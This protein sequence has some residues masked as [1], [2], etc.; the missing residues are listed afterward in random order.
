MFM[1]IR[2]LA[3]ASIALL[4][5]PFFADLPAVASA[6]AGAATCPNLYRNLSFG[7][8]GIDVV[9]LQ[10]FLITQGDLAAGNNTGYFGRLTEAAV[11]SWQ[12]R[13]GIVSSGTATTTG[14][15]AVGPRTR[16]NMTSV[17]GGGGTV[18]ANFSASPISGAAPLTVSFNYPG[19]T[20]G[21][22]S[23]DYGDGNSQAMKF[24]YP[25][26]TQIP[27]G[28]KDC[29]YYES[30][31]AYT[32]A[33][34]YTAKLMRD[35]TDCGVTKSIPGQM[36]CGPATV[37]GTV[38]IT[39]GGSANANVYLTRTPSPLS[40][41]RYAAFESP[42]PLSENVSAYSIDFGDGTTQKMG[43][44]MACA[45]AGGCTRFE[46]MHADHLY[47]AA[48]TYIVKLLRSAFA[49]PENGSCPPP[50]PV[51]IEPHIVNTITVTIP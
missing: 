6:Q 24:V 50:P 23:V 48:G 29:S 27:A 20:S 18:S 21:T 10:N 13:N 2:L 1:T 47:T 44:R 17:C 49:C 4:L 45:D 51:W 3:A 7:S 34:T 32:N 30:S 33:G 8:R 11:K 9:Q 46:G 39:V 41:P 36:Y 19:V 31:H 16:A 12:S 40:D 38:T 43:R 28:R 26:C 42:L 14:Y 5:V 25:S 35:S 37:V 22:Y 15:G